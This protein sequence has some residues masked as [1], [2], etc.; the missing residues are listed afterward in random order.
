MLPLSQAIRLPIVMRGK[1]VV[2]YTNKG[3][4]IF[5]SL[6]L[7]PGMLSFDMSHLD[8][9]Y[10]APN[11]VKIEGRL[12]IHGRGNHLKKALKLVIMYGSVQDVQS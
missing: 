6:Y 12:I 3:S 11:F 4:I 2:K 10:P 8:Y 9:S 7:R 5:T 1:T